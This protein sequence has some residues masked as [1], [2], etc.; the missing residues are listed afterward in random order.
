MGDPF[1]VDTSTLSLPSEGE[2]LKYN[3]NVDFCVAI[4]SMLSIEPENKDVYVEYQLPEILELDEKNIDVDS[5]IKC[6]QADDLIFV[7]LSISVKDSD[8]KSA[9]EVLLSEAQRFDEEIQLL[10]GN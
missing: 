10:G 3:L 7:I 2:A 5:A 6:L 4:E 1:W 9:V 8:I